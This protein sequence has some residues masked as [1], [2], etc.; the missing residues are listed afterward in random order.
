MKN[1][2]FL[3]SFLNFQI[4][5][6]RIRWYKYK[7]KLPLGPIHHAYPV[8][9]FVRVPVISVKT[10][11]HGKETPSTERIRN[12]LSRWKFHDTANVPIVRRQTQRA[13]HNRVKYQRN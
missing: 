3:F 5:I 13:N 8:R 11:F 1:E 9:S 6:K 12:R 7:L 10:D 4:V 2:L